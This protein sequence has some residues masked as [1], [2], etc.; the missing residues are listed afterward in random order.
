MG[1]KGSSAP[2]QRAL[3]QEELELLDSQRVSLDQATDVA[4][5]QYNLSNEDRE[6]VAQIYRG[7]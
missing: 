3:T 6:Y 2:A 5:K 4:S 1:S 7:D